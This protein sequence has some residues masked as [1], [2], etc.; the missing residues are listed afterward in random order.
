MNDDG[1]GSQF[2][3]FDLMTIGIQNLTALSITLSKKMQPLDTLQFTQAYITPHLILFLF[4]LF[5]HNHSQYSQTR[6]YF[7]IT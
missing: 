6:H 4:S 5:N 2:N 7:T 1:N 3:R